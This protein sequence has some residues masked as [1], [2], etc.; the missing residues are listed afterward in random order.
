[1]SARCPCPSSTMRCA[2]GRAAATP[3][4]SRGK[5]GGAPGDHQPLGELLVAAALPA[6]RPRTST[7]VSRAGRSQRTTPLVSH[8]GEQAPTASIRPPL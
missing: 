1:M 8:G 5:V 2:S 6:T 7:S 4:S 3:R